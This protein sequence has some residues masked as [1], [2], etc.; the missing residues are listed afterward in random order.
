MFKGPGDATWSAAPLT[1][2]ADTDRWYAPIT[3]DRIGRWAYTVEAWTDL[4]STWRAGLKKKLAADQDV[5]LELLEGARLARTAARGVKVAPIRAAL[6][7][8][9]RVLEDRR[10]MSV[11]QRVKRALDGELAAMMNEHFKPADLTRFRRELTIIVDREQARYSTWY[12]MF[13]LGPSL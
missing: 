11:E 10:Q 6:T 2:H 1:Y 5:Q 7:Q 3:L 13:P 9:A 4:F 8:T 12:E